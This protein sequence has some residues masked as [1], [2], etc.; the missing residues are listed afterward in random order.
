MS[1]IFEIFRIEKLIELGRFR[2]AEQQLAIAF[3]EDPDQADLKLLA[4]KLQYVKKDFRQ[5]LDIVQN[6]LAESPHDE[7]ALT[8]RFRIQESMELYAEA[9]QDIIT[10][11]QQYPQKGSYWASYALLLLKTGHTE[12]AFRLAE[13]AMRLDPEDSHCALV[14]C[15]VHLVQGSGKKIEAELE[16]LVRKNPDYEPTLYL[17]INKLAQSHKTKEA[18]A[19]ARHM[20]RLNPGDEDV[21]KQAKDLALH[22]HWSMKPFWIFNRFGWLGSAGLWLAFVVIIGMLE[23]S[24]AKNS[25]AI[26]FISMGYVGFCVASWVWPPLLKKWIHHKGFR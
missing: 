10:L 9:E 24:E 26:L 12:K 19:L 25:S 7:D 3:Q 8:L 2:E 1:S 16:Q 6:C 18:F 13:E 15:I 22:N 4:A 14:Y 23:K 20:V 5:A 11:L 17:V 21:V